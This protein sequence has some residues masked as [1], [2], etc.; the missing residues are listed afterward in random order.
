MHKQLYYHLAKQYEVLLTLVSITRGSINYATETSTET[1]T[2][3]PHKAIPLPWQ[4]CREY[5]KGLTSHNE[6]YERTY[7]F[8]TSQHLETN[9][10][11]LLHDDVRYNFKDVIELS[12]GFYI[13]VA[14][15]QAGEPSDE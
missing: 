15:A 7:F 5:F 13:V 4:I 8:K 14:S 1:V 2:E 9:K 6:K 3:I 10:F 11:Y 12:S